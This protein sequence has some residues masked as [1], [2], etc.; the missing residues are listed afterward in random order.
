ME[1]G[2][3]SILL[4]C[5]AL[6]CIFISLFT[7]VFAYLLRFL[8]VINGSISLIKAQQMCHPYNNRIDTLNEDKVQ[9]EQWNRQRQLK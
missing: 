5:I 2:N 4:H 7:T 6:H 1:A 3:T 9:P 8:P